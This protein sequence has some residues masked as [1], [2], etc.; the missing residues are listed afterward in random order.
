MKIGNATM[1]IMVVA[2]LAAPAVFAHPGHVHVPGPVHGFSWVDLLG[3]LL[4]S[5]ALPVD[6]WLVVRAR[7]HRR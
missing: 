7:R 6:A 4:V 2:L 3:F 5:V 1:V